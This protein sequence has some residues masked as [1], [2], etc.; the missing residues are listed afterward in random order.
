MKSDRNLRGDV[1]AYLDWL[2]EELG[3][4][5]DDK[6]EEGDR[7]AFVQDVQGRAF[8][9]PRQL[10][11]WVGH[12]L[13]LV[14]SLTKG[15]I[16]P[17]DV[18]LFWIGLQGIFGDIIPHLKGLANILPGADHGFST[19]FEQL[20]ALLSET[21]LTVV[22]Y[23]RQSQVHPFPHV[24]HVKGKFPKL[25]WTYKGKHMNE[26]NKEVDEV[27]TQAATRYGVPVYDAD[28]YVA[29]DIA[30]RIYRPLNEIHKDLVSWIN[31]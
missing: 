29:R 10:S 4:T 14:E 13:R 8:E 25:N 27:L 22:D 26:L 1:D 28:G 11:Q 20:Q 18:A 15:P 3:I 6:L 24:L 2:K 23:H 17:R 19:R 16:D 30:E 12:T 9:I 5:L 21:E 7:E 31:A